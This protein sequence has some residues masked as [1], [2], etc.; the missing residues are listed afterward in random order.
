[1]GWLDTLRRIARR[2]A[3]GPK[4]DREAQLLQRTKV[5]TTSAGRRRPPSLT[6]LQ[7]FVELSKIYERRGAIDQAHD[8]MQQALTLTHGAVHPAVAIAVVTRLAL[9]TAK[10]SGLTEGEAII[11]QHRDKLSRA[12]GDDGPAQTALTCSIAELRWWAGE[13][14]GARIGWRSALQQELPDV[15]AQGDPFRTAG[16]FAKPRGDAGYLLVRL[17]MTLEQFDAAQE[18]LDGLGHAHTTMDMVHRLFVGTLWRHR[19]EYDHA[20]HEYDR[21]AADMDTRRIPVQAPLRHTLS[22]ARGRLAAARG[23]KDAALAHTLQALAGYS[24]IH[25]D[26]DESLVA[27]LSDAGMAYLEVECVD[28]AGRLTL[29]ALELGQRWRTEAITLADTEVAHARTLRATS[30]GSSTDTVDALLAS[31]DRRLAVGMPLTN[32]RRQHIATLR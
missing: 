14:D 27:I 28:Q 32:G 4:L 20:A 21:A 29:R 2:D 5:W 9:L 10:T 18:L 24:G 16:Q 6:D 23:D 30:T 22:H 3:S 15:P 11:D 19:Q 25:G 26:D 8:T 1:M 13:L 7:Q 17:E 12:P 31:A